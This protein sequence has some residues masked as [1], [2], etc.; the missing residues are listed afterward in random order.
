[1]RRFYSSKWA[2]VAVL[3]LLVAMVVVAC[4]GGGATPAPA[5]EGGQTDTG[6][7]GGEAATGGEGGGAE[8]ITINFLTIDDQDQ[9]LALEEMANAFAESDPQWAN[10]DVEI[11]AVPFEQLFPKIEAS[12]ATGADFDAFLADGPDIKH[13]AYNSAIIPLEEYYTQDEIN[14]Y[15]PATIEEGSFNG[16]FYSPA[17]MQSCSMMFY[18][19]E[20]T[21]AAG[22][23][24]PQQVDGYTM[25][26][27][28]DAWL[29]SQVDEDGDGSPEV[30]GLRW[31]QGTWWGDYEHG[32]IRRSAGERGSPTFQG[33]GDDGITFKGYID[34]PE[35]LNS[36]QTYRDWHQGDRRVS[37]AE[38]IPDIFVGRQSAFYVSPDNAIGQINRLYPEGDF[39]YGV[40]G[41]PY[42]ADGSQLCHTGSWHLG[43]TPSTDKRE[44]A[45]A[46]VK[47][48]AGPEGSRIWYDHVRQ[49]PARLDM[50]NELPE[51]NEYPQQLFSTGLQEIGVPRIQTPC[52]TE[53]QQ[54]F[55]ELMQNVSQSTDIDVETL[56]EDAAT[57]MEQA[58]A[59]YEGWQDK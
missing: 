6:G 5:D 41:I 50:L 3:L 7:D 33:M 11:Q 51:Y 1:M 49:L 35:A 55:A 10:V 30:W 53:Y 32:I 14:A 45:V 26:E 43:V 20:F 24:P 46:M 31:G 48:F 25:D 27:A 44:A 38:P 34:T 29:K 37:P 47:F 19:R 28:W 12:V 39:D 21:D 52:Y 18:N 8:A 16:T 40:T 56:V 23:E 22:V 17:L 57:Q 59:K 54:V 13:Y 58:C 4:G 9:L 15:V 36:F 2:A 42:F